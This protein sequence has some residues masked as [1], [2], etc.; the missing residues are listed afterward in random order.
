MALYPTLVVKVI[1]TASCP[2]L[3]AGWRG[4]LLELTMIA[5]CTAMEHP[6]ARAPL[7]KARW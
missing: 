2:E 7:A 4:W 3:A 6:S 1:S 5:V